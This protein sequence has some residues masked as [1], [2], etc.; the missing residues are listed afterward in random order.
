M[1][2]NRLLPPNAT[3]IERGFDDAG[4]RV[5][6]LPVPV[7]DIWNPAACPG[8]LLPWLAWA[9]SVDRWDDAWSVQQQRAVIAASVEVHRRKGTI[10]AI[11]AALA[12]EGYGGATVIEAIG[13]HDFDGTYDHDGAI[14]Y[15]PRGHWAEYRVIM[16]RPVSI[17]QADGIRA[18]LEQVAPARCHL[19]SLE[20]VAAA[21]LYNSEIVYDGSFTHGEV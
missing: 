7:G 15:E 5:T 14:V 3:A 6:E 1:S 13:N 12:A 9:L 21:H 4:S 20:F 19:E 18:V 16:D 17:G 11:R 2:D 8:H 10:G